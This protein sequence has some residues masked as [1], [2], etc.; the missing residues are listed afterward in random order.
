LFWVGFGRVAAGD[1]A[2]ARL[3]AV[4]A[5]AIDAPAPAVQGLLARIAEADARAA[6]ERAEQQRAAE[7]AKQARE[8]DQKVS[9]LIG[10]ARKAKK[11]AEALKLLEEAQRVD[12]QRPELAALIAERQAEIA[13]P[14][15]QAPVKPPVQAPAHTPERRP[16]T[17]GVPDH[18]TRSP[19]SPGMLGGIAAGIVVLIVALWY[20]LRTPTPDPGP[21]DGTTTN[22]GPVAPGPNPGPGPGP[23]PVVPAAP[24]QVRIDSIPWSRVTLTPVAGGPATTCT[25]PCQLSLAPGEYQLAM[26]NP[27]I[28]EPLSARVV[29]L[30]GEP[31]DV[32]K[33]LSG[34]DLE[35]AVSAIVR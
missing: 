33:E 3:C 30:A 31:V 25:T 15:P 34:F 10:K 26:A 8:R 9:T 1:L 16:A 12:P 27:D 4:A 19:L 14:P 28:P 5:A 7:A 22:G 23:G 18:R 11:P 21:N 24:S 20:F 17:S 13:H 32:R 6:Q 35:R 2:G 29:V